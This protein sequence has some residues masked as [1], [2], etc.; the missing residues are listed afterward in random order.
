MWCQE[1]DMTEH[2]S[3]FLVTLPLPTL[4]LPHIHSPYAV[5]TDRSQLCCN[6]LMFPRSLLPSRIFMLMPLSYL[7][8]NR[9]K[10]LRS[11]ENIMLCNHWSR[12]THSITR[13]FTISYHAA[14]SSSL[15]LWFLFW[16]MCLLPTDCEQLDSKNQFFH[17]YVSTASHWL[18]ESPTN[19]CCCNYTRPNISSSLSTTLFWL[20][21]FFLGLSP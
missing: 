17:H 14:D 8:K 16:S 9:T 10:F 13:N 7:I 6:V 4:P 19:L 3:T 11:N 20:S 21:S 12:T 1:L 5:A 15:I 18:V 2:T